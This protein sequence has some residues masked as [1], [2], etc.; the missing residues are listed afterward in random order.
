[1]KKIEIIWRELL[2]QV[3]EKGNRRFTQKEIASKFSYSTSTVFQA[4]KVPRKMGAIKVSGRLFT[5]EDWE[6]LLYYWASIR[7]MEQEVKLLKH[8]NLPIFEIE[9]KMPPNIVFGGFIA[10]RQILKGDVPADYDMVLVYA[11]TLD[12]ITKRFEFTKGRNNLMVLAAD[13]Y[14]ITYGQITTIAQTFVDLWNLPYWYAKE[15]TR[16]LKEKIDELLP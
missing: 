14:L 9:G 7:N 4:L 15:Y 11:S 10:A 12:E 2:H 8:V 13:P 16:S 3:I 1:M 5:I 6:K